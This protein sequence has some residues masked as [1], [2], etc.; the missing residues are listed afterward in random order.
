MVMFLDGFLHSI[1]CEISLSEAEFWVGLQGLCSP[2]DA[3]K[4]N[5]LYVE[6]ISEAV[7]RC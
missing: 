5:V 7:C 3:G 6:A 4:V 2:G 1:S